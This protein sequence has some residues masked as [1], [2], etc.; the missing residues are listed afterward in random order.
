MER[1]HTSIVLH[2][3]ADTRTSSAKYVARQFSRLTEPLAPPAPTSRVRQ[4]NRWKVT[5]F[6]FFALYVTSDLLA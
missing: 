1:L 3:A 6:V 4:W 5:L 2:Q